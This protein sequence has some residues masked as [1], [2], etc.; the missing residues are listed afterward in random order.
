MA[1]GLLTIRRV[2]DRDVVR[3]ENDACIE[4]TIMKEFFYR[5]VNKKQM[6]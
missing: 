6:W 2:G 4:Q 1:G 3:G 5:K